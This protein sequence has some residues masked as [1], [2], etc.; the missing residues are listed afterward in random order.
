MNAEDAASLLSAGPILLYDGEC[1]VC[2][3]AVQWILARDRER[4]LRFAA[5]ESAL[6]RDLRALC[7]VDPRV[8][9]LLWIERAG[10]GTHRSETRSSEAPSSSA[11]S[12]AAPAAVR[13]R[14]H[15]EAVR[16][17]LAYLGGWRARVGRL[18]GLVPRPLADLGYRTFARHRLAVAPRMCLLPT[19]EQRTR[20]LGT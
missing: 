7:A 1:G 12:I 10:A 11:L 8:D 3:G 19:P 4:S 15:S 13:V 5:L 2:S 18:L 6:G 20:F 16:A 17:V 14:M 9:S